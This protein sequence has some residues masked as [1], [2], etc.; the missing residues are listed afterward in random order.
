MRLHKIA[1]AALAAALVSPLAACGAREQA[2]EAKPLRIIAD[3]IPHA[4]LLNKAADLGLLG[5]VK[6]DVT[7]ISGDVDPNQLVNAGDL[8]ANFFQHVPYL[9]DWNAAHEGS[10]LVAVATVHVEP[11]GLYSKKVDSLAAIPTD[12]TIA[13]PAD[14]TNLARALFLLQD[15]G[16][17]TL[18]VKADDPGLDY[19]QITEA[20]ITGNRSEE[21]R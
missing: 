6:L 17:I 3:V 2:P 7:E 20:N 18:D 13:I 5:D 8:D 11:L 19:A 10:D 15:A 12:A 14:P 1:L 16:L 4:E 21:R 9:D